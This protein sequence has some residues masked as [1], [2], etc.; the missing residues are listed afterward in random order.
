MPEGAHVKRILGDSYELRHVH[1]L[2]E[3][4]WRTDPS[5]QHGMEAAS[6]LAGL[7]RIELIKHG[8]VE[9]YDIAD[10]SDILNW[11]SDN[12]DFKSSWQH[13]FAECLSCLETFFK[14]PIGEVVGAQDCHY[15]MK[16]LADLAQ[17]MTTLMI[18]D[19]ARFAEHARQEAE[20]LNEKLTPAA[21]FG[22]P[23]MDHANN[24]PRKGGPI[25]VRIREILTRARRNNPRISND[26]LWEEFKKKP[27]KG[28]TPMDNREGRYIEGP[29][30]KKNCDF[31]RFKTVASEERGKLGISLRKRS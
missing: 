15:A 6:R 24:P 11:L 4:Q 20:S 29:K 2:I 21:E 23:F 30:Y 28:Y 19:A 5:W 14:E 17:R 13:S 31:G 3:E 26:D 18:A 22:G 12:E 9:P 27:P 25:R 10:S 8:G 7:I 1:D 16:C